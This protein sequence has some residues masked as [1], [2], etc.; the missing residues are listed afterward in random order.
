MQVYSF[1]LTELRYLTVL[2]YS[3]RVIQ[4]HKESKQRHPTVSCFVVSFRCRSAPRHFPYRLHEIIKSYQRILLIPTKQT[5]RS[6]CDLDSV[7][8]MLRYFF[9]SLV[10]FSYEFRVVDLIEKIKLSS[11][12][13]AFQYEY[14]STSSSQSYLKRSSVWTHR[15]TEILKR[16]ELDRKL[17]FKKRYNESLLQEYHHP[18]TNTGG[19]VWRSSDIAP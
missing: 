12:G 8:I 11:C 4:C 14:W 7:L 5:I 15:Y 10:T 13:S 1:V 3:V 19:T 9:K 18:Q 17:Y 16:V 6:K 2:S